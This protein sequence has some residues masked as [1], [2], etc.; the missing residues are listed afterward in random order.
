M[1]NQMKIRIKRDSE[2][3][4]IPKYESEGASGFDLCAYID[5][6]VFIEST[7]IAVIPTGLHFEIP[8][9]FEIQV[10]SRSGLAANS[11]IMVLNSPGTV[12]SDYRGEVKVILINLGSERFKV[13][14]E[15]RIAQAVVT[16]VQEVTFHDI[17]S[18]P[19][20]RSMRGSGGFGSTGINKEKGLI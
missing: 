15:D 14:N 4:K 20:S 9:G 2:E 5:S 17:G 13:S 11:G 18:K 8:I 1:R 10:R 12:D 16:I 19:L 7:S 6:P 3:V